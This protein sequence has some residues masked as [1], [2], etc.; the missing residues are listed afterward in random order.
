MQ[1]A[2][3]PNSD[4]IA[5]FLVVPVW[6][7]RSHQSAWEIVRS[8]V[9]GYLEEEEDE[10]EDEHE[11]GEEDKVGEAKRAPVPNAINKFRIAGKAVI[12]QARKPAATRGVVDFDLVRGRVLV[13]HNVP[14]LFFGVTT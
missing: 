2:G 1:L 7:P 9:V 6:L 12:M 14:P 8:L 13:L 11:K 3:A 4:P 10:D 5:S